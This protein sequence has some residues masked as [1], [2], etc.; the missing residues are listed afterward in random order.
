MDLQS[1]QTPDLH[2]PP[3]SIGGT[4]SQGSPQ[5]A[6]SDLGLPPLS[7][8]SSTPTS[9]SATPQLPQT[10][11]YDDAT[12]NPSTAQL[13]EDEADDL[14]AEWVNKARRIVEHTK[15]DPYL[16]SREISKVKSEYLRIRYNK[17]TKIAPDHK[18]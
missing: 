3:P 15:D 18:S 4:S 11:N 14:D 2:L 16:Q 10:S 13:K 5:T 12:P 7:G 17:H 8:D 6:S 1:K 9:A